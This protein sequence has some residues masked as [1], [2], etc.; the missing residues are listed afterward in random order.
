MAT[1]CKQMRL[2]VADKVGR[3]AEIT[4][5]I[6]DAGVNILALCAWTEDGRGHLMMVTDDNTK[7]CEA[8]GESVD[9]CDRETDCLCVNVPN[10]PGALNEVARKLAEAGIGIEVCFATP[11]SAEQATIILITDDNGRAQEVL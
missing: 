11:G 6:K 9:K 3:L 10:K 1:V 7:A 5:K 4:E 8:I 2:E